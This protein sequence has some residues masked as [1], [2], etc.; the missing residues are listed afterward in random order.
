MP[1]LDEIQNQEIRSKLASAGIPD[2]DT[3]AQRF[4]DGQTMIST[5]VRWPGADAGPEAR[6]K[7]NS[8]IG[9]PDSAEGY[10]V[11]DGSLSGV[12]DAARAAAHRAGLTPSQW[13]GVASQMNQGFDAQRQQ[14]MDQYRSEWDS[15][16][17]EVKEQLGSYDQAVANAQA[18]SLKL[19][20][21]AGA[22]T[23]R[24]LGVSNHPGFIEHMSKL[25]SQ[26]NGGTA[27]PPGAG[28]IQGTGQTMDVAQARALATEAQGIFQSDEYKQ[29][30]HPARAMNQARLEEIYG[31]MQSLGFTGVNDPK[32]FAGTSYTPPKTVF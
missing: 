14:T 11:A 12:L 29:M 13:E 27:L 28:G 5:S 17:A 18:A 31:I 30:N 23:M 24:D 10:K 16:A 26:M 22:N 9:V 20:G 15:K 6:A 2:M 4:I 7:F 19:F 1:G 32:L 8:A 3:L 25:G 21:E